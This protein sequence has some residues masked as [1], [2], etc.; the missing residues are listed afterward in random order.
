M[1]NAYSTKKQQT[2][3][4]HKKI[5]AKV[6]GTGAKPRLAVFR[7][8]TAV[9]GQLIDDTTGKTL[10]AATTAEVKTGTVLERARAAGKLIAK[11]AETLKLTSVVF[12]R[13][14]FK[15]AGRVQA[16]AD[17]AREGGLRF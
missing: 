5:R 2:V 12:D 6:S 9:Y 7:S 14:G 17:G 1:S 16:F 15:Y 11:K 8:N 13:G 4:R 3:Q 10:V